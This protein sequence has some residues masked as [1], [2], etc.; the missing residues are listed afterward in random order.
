MLSI[1]LR[2]S[3]GNQFLGKRSARLRPRPMG[4]TLNP[5]P[6][7][8]TLRR[9]VLICNQGIAYKVNLIGEYYVQAR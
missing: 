3:S 5:Q 6:T 9:T 8:C 7:G 2:V 4:Q 1:G